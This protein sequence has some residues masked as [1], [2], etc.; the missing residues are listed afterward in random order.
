[1]KSLG[2]KTTFFSI[3]LT[4]FVDYLSWAVVFP[5]FAPYF[6]DTNNHL[7]SPDVLAGTRS[8]V[9]GFF[10]MA[11]SLGQFLGAPLIGEYADKHGRKKALA[12]S[13]F[14]TFLGLCISAYSMQIN[15]LYWLFAGRLITGIFASSASVCLTC[16][17]DLSE[18][19]KAKVKNYGTLS[20]I[21]GLA[22]VIGAFAGGKLSDQT[23]NSSFTPNLPFWIAAA[24][25]LLN[26]LFILFGFKE[27]SVIHPN[28]RFDF[29][30]SFKNIKIAL[31]TAKVKRIYTVY[32]FFLFGW[33]ILF[34]FMPVL[35]VQK[36]SFTNSNIGDLALFMGACWAIGSGYL[37]KFFVNRFD[38]MLILEL[39]LIGFTLF[40]GLIVFASHIYAILT[41]VGLCIV[42]GGIG[43][44]ICTGLISSRAPLAMQGKVLGLSQSV[45]SLAMTVGPLVGGLAFN[46]SFFLPFL[47]ASGVSLIAVV[48]YYFVLKHR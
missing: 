26:F 24:F 45:Q 13:V 35:T 21:A 30:E 5:I 27:T 20:M 7:F 37:N 43:W 42:F 1:M 8:M 18:T 28:V 6:L 19:E 4:F 41:I 48:I 40:C 39:C 14:F 29:F 10:L 22:F 47:I 33:T 36:F 44:P 16:V 23:I 25:T 2:K 34:Q 46:Y 32:F 38:S 3:Y 11:F 17:S 15:N 9:L 12:I 31:K